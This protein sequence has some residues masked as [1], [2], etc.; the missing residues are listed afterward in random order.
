MCLVQVIW[1]A[2]FTLQVEDELYLIGKISFL[3]GPVI[4]TFDLIYNTIFILFLKTSLNRLIRHS[5]SIDM[6]HGC[7]FWIIKKHE[8]NEEP[9][10]TSMIW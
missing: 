8:L 10:L 7:F 6:C 2:R 3:I 5:F 4:V 9:F 1:L